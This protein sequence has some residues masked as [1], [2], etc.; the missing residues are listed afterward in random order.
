LADRTVRPEI[1][2]HREIDSTHLFGKGFVRKRRVNAYAQDLSIAGL[3]FFSI[4]FEA[5]Q[6]PLSASRKIEWIK[7]QDNVLLAAVIAQGNI[8]LA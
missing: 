7:R 4:F 5:A 8:L 1:R 6:F 2:K 3:E